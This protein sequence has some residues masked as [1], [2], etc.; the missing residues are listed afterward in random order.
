MRIFD[1]KLWNWDQIFKKEDLTI[2]VSLPS[3]CTSTAVSAASTL[4]ATA[5]N[6][7]I[8]RPV[9]V[10]LIRDFEA[11]YVFHDGDKLFNGPHTYSFCP[12]SF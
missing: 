4:P 3:E 9:D 7:A 12:G 11:T 2:E 10:T 8:N 1:L 5:G 6:P